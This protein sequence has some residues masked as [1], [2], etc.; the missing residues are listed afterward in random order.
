M[1]L[2]LPF[3]NRISGSFHF[4]GRE[5]RLEPNLDG[6]PFPIHGD[7]FQ[8]SWEVADR[9]GEGVRLRLPDGS[10][11]PFSYEA[12]VAYCLSPTAL[13][14]T[15][16]VTSL[17][18]EPLPF[19]LGFHPWFPRSSGTRLRFRAAGCWPQD[20]RHLPATSGPAP[21]P[22]DWDFGVPAPPPEGWINTAFSGW[23]GEAELWH[24]V[25]AVSLRI[26]APDLRTLIVYSPSA[27]A[28]FLCLEPVSHPVDAH[29]LPGQPGL[30]RLEPGASL[31][32]GMTL[33]WDPGSC[34]DPPQDAGRGS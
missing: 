24:D 10:F 32:A 5:H 29:N 6:E 30:V 33:S 27:A 18:R 8:R 1:N 12:E 28:P 4:E 2:L 20:D 23:D 13:A 34:G 14:T 9:D 3:S 15:L 19:G 11:G 25:S 7:A 22:P 17:S 21:I 31:S 26:T 16:A